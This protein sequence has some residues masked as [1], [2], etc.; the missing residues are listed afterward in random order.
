MLWEKVIGRVDQRKKLAGTLAL[1]I[2]SYV[3]P[4]LAGTLALP[5]VS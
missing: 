2:V 3:L 1:P 4:K 5:I